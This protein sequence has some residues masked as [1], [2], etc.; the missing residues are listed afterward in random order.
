MLIASKE[1]EVSRWTCAFLVAL[2]FVA[3]GYTCI[4]DMYYGGIENAADSGVSTWLLS[5]G[6]FT[7]SGFAFG[8][9]CLSGN[10]LRSGKRFTGIGVTGII[11]CF[12]CFS[13]FNGIGFVSGQTRG[14]A[15]LLEARQEQA[16]DIATI[17][18]QQAL[19]NQ[20][21]LKRTYLSTRDPKEKQE[22]LSKAVAPVELQ[23]AE[24][25]M[26]ISDAR[27]E[28][29]ST[30]LG[31]R[32]ESVQFGYA[33]AF[34]ILLILGKLLGPMCGFAFWPLNKGDN[35]QHKDQQTAHQQ[36]LRLSADESMHVTSPGVTNVTGVTGAKMTAAGALIDVRKLI[37]EQGSMPSHRALARRWNVTPMTVSRWCK[38][39]ERNGDIA[40]RLN[41]N[42]HTI[43]HAPGNARSNKR[44][45][46]VAK[47]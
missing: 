41:G 45:M 44:V 36:K 17:K 39:W 23:A 11:A 9:S 12:L 38:K 34:S 24:I 3:Y 8:F 22:L 4:V 15:K 5:A 21:W 10:L 31:W 30:I 46:H 35:R 26:V 47:Q 33:V 43:V 25:G 28:A 37:D 1:I 14:K 13:L 32:Q 6:M 19:N 20:E 29:I 42:G 2:G 18:N 7:M 40:R 16:K 27:A